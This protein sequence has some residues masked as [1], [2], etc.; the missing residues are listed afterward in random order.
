MKRTGLPRASTLTL[1]L[2]RRRPRERGDRLIALRPFLHRAEEEALKQDKL[3][4]ERIS[5]NGNFCERSI[6]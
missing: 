1:I 6:V 5:L 3:R 4:N 2:V